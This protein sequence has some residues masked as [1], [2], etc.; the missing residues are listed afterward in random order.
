MKTKAA[1]RGNP[2]ES[3]PN[4]DTPHRLLAAGCDVTSGRAVHPSYTWTTLLAK[5]LNVPHWS[6]A[7]PH[8]SAHAISRLLYLSLPVLRPQV[9][10]VVLPPP[11]H[12]EIVVDGVV[13]DWTPSH[14]YDPEVDGAMRDLFENGKQWL[15]YGSAL[16]FMTNLCALNNATLFLSSWWEGVRFDLFPE[17]AAASFLP[18]SLTDT[19]EGH[20]TF[21]NNL[22]PL[23]RSALDCN[24]G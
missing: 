22:A 1:W 12:R 13:W 9:V 10:V 15:D 20:A 23:C 5:N 24:G 3:F 4:K 16:S 19:A 11:L 2:G 14:G 18:F 8:L 6:L 7:R 17:N 21:A